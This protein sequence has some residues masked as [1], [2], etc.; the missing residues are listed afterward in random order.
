MAPL[1]PERGIEYPPFAVAGPFFSRENNDKHYL[2]IFTCAVACAVHLELVPSM[3]AKHF[4]L[5][6]QQFISYY[7]LCSTIY[8]DD[9]KSFKR[10]NIELKKL[11]KSINDLFRVISYIS[12]CKIHLLQHFDLFSYFRI[13]RSSHFF[14]HFLIPSST[15]PEYCNTLF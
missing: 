9:A 7:G 6:F 10:A 4:L 15:T 13:R 8:S 14:S 2:L 5:S 3:H 11:W 12:Q 1:P